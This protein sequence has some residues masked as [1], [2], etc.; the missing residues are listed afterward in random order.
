MLNGNPSKLPAGALLDGV[1]PDVEIPDCPTW[2]MPDAKREWK[3]ITPQLEGLR[4]V[5]QLD[6]AEL[7]V[8]CQEFARWKQAERKIAEL[9]K[10]DPEGLAGLIG[11]TPS[12]YKQ[13]SVLLQIVRSSQE[14]MMKAA[15][16][17]GLNP[18]ARRGVT[19]SEAG[20][21][22][23]LPGLDAP[24]LPQAGWQSFK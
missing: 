8:Y 21:Q 23:S 19:P 12:G 1:N 17:F 10:G 20:S 2:L 13:I 16:S 3:R 18:A 24:Q 22:P 4:L 14:K 9:N 5:S 7:A 6:L 11:V 15:A